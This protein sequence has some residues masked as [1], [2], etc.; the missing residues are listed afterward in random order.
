[1]KELIT[2]AA[3][4]LPIIGGWVYVGSILRGTTKP[5]RTMRLLV[6]LVTGVSFFALINSSGGGLLLALASFLQAIIIFLLAQKF[7]VG[8]RHKIDFICAGLCA[9]GI[10]VWAGTGAPAVALAASIIADFV[11][12]APSLIKTYRLPHTE[13]W[14]FYLLDALS[15]L[16]FIV[17]GPYTLLS[18]IYPLYIFVVNAIFVAIIMRRRFFDKPL[19]R[20]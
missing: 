19:L 14:L 15:A 8:G 18:Q 7:G 12:V 16:L 11:A 5:Q 9:L 10:V 20:R 13:N 6:V 1:M 2:A 3:T 4:C 17:V